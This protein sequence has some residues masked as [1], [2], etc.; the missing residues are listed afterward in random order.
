MLR[1]R[2]T[3][4]PFQFVLEPDVWWEVVLNISRQVKS[5]PQTPPAG[6]LVIAQKETIY[7]QKSDHVSPKIDCSPIITEH[8]PKKY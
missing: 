5:F 7:P 1:R 8:F 4:K 2:G 3:Q 6:S